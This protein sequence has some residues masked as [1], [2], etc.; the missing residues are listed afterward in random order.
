MIHKLLAALATAGI[1]TIAA[2]PVQAVAL[3][4]EA[5]QMDH[6]SVTVIGKGSPVILIPGLASPRAVWDGV[7]PALARTHTVY[8]VQLNGFGGDDPRG[9]LKPGILNG[10]VEDLHGLIAARKLQGA[11]VI[12]HSMGGLAGLMLAKA[13][14][15]DLSK[16]MIVDSL[17][18]IG[19]IFM[20]NPSVAALEPQ[21][22]AL[23][24]Q[25]AAAYG[26]PVDEAGNA[27]TA[28]GLA[29]K[30]ESRTRVTGWLRA[31]DGRVSGQ[32]LYEDLTTDLRT[33]MAGIQTPITLVYPWSAAM[34]QARAEAFYKAQYA[35][36]PH[37]TLIG[38]AD[39]AHFAML[40]QPE[41]FEA[42]AV[43]FAGK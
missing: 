19:A 37:V 41:A 30:P 11:A 12:G 1:S 31:V 22:G 14:P 26:K 3:V 28:A 21:A 34:P 7:A 8:L 23:R 25:M 18:F 10:M 43:S 9:N 5:I 33:D 17:P 6:I 24:G 16:L 36:T 39:A 38:I 15:G 29:L 40:D 20:P 32:A 27:R 2:Q 13:H 4:P 35:G 42:A